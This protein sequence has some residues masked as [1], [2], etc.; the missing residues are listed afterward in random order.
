MPSCKDVMVQPGCHTN[1]ASEM[2][3]CELDFLA[4]QAA[5]ELHVHWWLTSP[6][7]APCVP[8]RRGGGA[9]ARSA[10]PRALDFADTAPARPT[11]VVASRA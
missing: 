1:V 11:A 6:A 2:L 9:A 8:C 4:G 10:A 3:V 5:A 7:P